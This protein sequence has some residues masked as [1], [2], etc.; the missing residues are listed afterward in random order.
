MIVIGQG[1]LVSFEDDQ[2]YKT[3]PVWSKSNILYTMQFNDKI[4]PC[5]VFLI[6]LASFGI[7]IYA[8]A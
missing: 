5:L 6:Y 8:E 7:K 2:G 4:D 1:S 3:W